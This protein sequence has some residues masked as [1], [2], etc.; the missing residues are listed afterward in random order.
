VVVS[1]FLLVE[2]PFLTDKSLPYLEDLV[3]GVVIIINLIFLFVCW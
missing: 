1:E 2:S 3:L